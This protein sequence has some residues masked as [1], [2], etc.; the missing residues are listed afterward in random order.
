MKLEF[1]TRFIMPLNNG[2]PLENILNLTGLVLSSR[3]INHEIPISLDID[4]EVFTKKIAPD[5][6]DLFSRIQEL[7]DISD[8]LGMQYKR[9]EAKTQASNRGVFITFHCYN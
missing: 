2:I 3:K 5:D 9:V 8:S 7:R 4:P 6:N 1:Q